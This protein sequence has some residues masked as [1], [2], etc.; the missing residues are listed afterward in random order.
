MLGGVA[1]GKKP[2]GARGQFL[3]WHGR[4]IPGSTHPALVTECTAEQW[5]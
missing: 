5:K 3:V 2:A 4:E 1:G